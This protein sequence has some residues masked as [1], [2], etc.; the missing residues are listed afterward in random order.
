MSAEDSIENPTGSYHGDMLEG[1][2]YVNTIKGLSGD[3]VLQGY[4]DADTIDGGDGIDTVIYGGS[5][6]GVSVCLFNGVTHGGDAE[7]DTLISIENL[8]GSNTERKIAV[9]AL[10]LS[11]RVPQLVEL[12]R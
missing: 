6:L 5:V 7:G 4:G 12:I 8:R 1:D 10:L 9:L 11:H 3:D 2:E